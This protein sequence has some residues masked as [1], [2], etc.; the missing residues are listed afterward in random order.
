MDN[1][2]SLCETFLS[3]HLRNENVIDLLIIADKHDAQKLKNACVR[4][5]I[6]NMANIHE[7]E[8]ILKLSKPLFVELLKYSTLGPKGIKF[9]R[10]IK[11]NVLGLGMKTNTIVER[12]SERK[13]SKI[14]VESKSESEE[15]EIIIRKRTPKKDV[16]KKKVVETESSSSETESVSQS[17]SRSKN[18]F[19]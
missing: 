17:R 4:F 18:S 12:E 1:L 11:E 10:K 8:E 3:K 6:E 5:I 16:C 13:V 15:E 2:K 9:I 7:T 19:E 14:K